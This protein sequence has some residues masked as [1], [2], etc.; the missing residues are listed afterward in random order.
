MNTRNNRRA[1]DSI[2]RIIRAVFGI[3]QTEG[4]PL[5]KITVR[6]VC[7]RAGINRSTFYAH[8]RDVYDV[9]ESVEKRMAEMAGKAFMDHLREGDSIRMG[10]EGLF[11]F[12]REYKE[13]Y[14]LYLGE[15]H[16]IRAIEMMVEP[17]QERLKQVD[18][19]E[20]GCVVEGEA[21]YRQDF[22]SSGLAAMLYRWL[23][24]GCRETP[25]QLFEILTR[26]YTQSF[27][28]LQ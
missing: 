25:R 6:E 12:V 23:K 9:G 17:H 20:L 1:Q 2:E 10:F 28:F 5:G 13:F 27:S 26:Q 8:Y 14:L 19:K 16:R 4:K 21:E 3:M 18:P 22:F 15:S 7:E 24:N 11:E